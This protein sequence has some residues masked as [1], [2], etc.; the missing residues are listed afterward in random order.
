M[1]GLVCL[2]FPAAV[3]VS[4]TLSTRKNLIRT[5][6]TLLLAP[7]VLVTLMFF[8][9]LT[10]T[11]APSSLVPEVSDTLIAADTIVYTLLYLFTIFVIILL[12]K[13]LTPQHRVRI[14]AESSLFAACTKAQIVKCIVASVILF[15]GLFMYYLVENIIDMFGSLQMGELIFQMSV[16]LEG[17]NTNFIPQLAQDA[18][19]PALVWL[20]LFVT[21][22]G[23]LYSYS[24]AAQ[25][26]LLRKTKRRP[27]FP[28]PTAFLRKHS[29][30]V[31]CAASIVLFAIS[32]NSLG[33]ANTFT[34][35]FS[36]SSFVE[37]NYTDPRTVPLTFPE[38]KK[39]LI[40]IML[41]SI[42]NTY[43]TPD[44]G[45]AMGENLI[46]ELTAFA[47]DPDSVSFSNTGNL[48]GGAVPLYSCTFTFGSTVAQTSGLPF[49]V[50]LDNSQWNAM[51]KYEVLLPGAYTIGEALDKEEYNQVYL[52]GSHASFAGRG[53]YFTQHG[54]YTIKDYSTA[55]EDGIIP[56]DYHVWWGFEDTRL[57][58]YAKQELTALAA[59]DQ[60]FNL[61]MLT[62]DTHAMDGY[63]C[64]LCS[65]DY[66][67]QYANVI[68]CASR[69][70]H[71]FMQ[72]LQEQD[73]YE[74]T[75]VVLYGDHNSMDATFF[76][77]LDQEYQRTTYNLIFNSSL[78]KANTYNRIF[79]PMDMFPTTLAAMGVEIPGGQLG[80]G[81]DLFSGVP[82]VLEKYGE[83]YVNSEL[84]KRSPFYCEKVC[85]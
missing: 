62:V 55:A 50:P 2:L 82:T 56:Q 30:L 72:W 20:A 35:L 21:F 28:I 44:L 70:L 81:V 69:Q 42:E 37:D 24:I 31:S 52:V 73:F 41:E 12:Y 29:L 65:A 58:D 33:F 67:E 8:S 9:M 40:Y 76:K 47:Q 85:K 38:Q 27:F 15:L 3:T 66:D 13:T 53:K 45:G 77:D 10:G 71:A 79:T 75:V 60:P 51:D 59:E 80:M 26:T 25:E 11:A 83:S 17:A 49:I 74:D 4:L 19:L 61:T 63:V 7:L 84:A 78:E 54:N 16:P 23:S 6:D 36:T 22:L 64:D 48:L 18:V 39:N 14:L 32:F 34:Y 43:A 57:Y 1:T 68:S 5:P 46:P